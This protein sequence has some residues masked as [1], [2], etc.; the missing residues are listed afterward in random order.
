MPRVRRRTDG[1]HGH[2]V[3]QVQGRLQRGRTAKRVPDEDV[4]RAILLA[5]PGRRGNEVGDV[6]GKGG[7]AESAF[8]LAQPRKIE[9]Q[10]SDALVDEGSAHVTRSLQVLRAGEAVGE[11][12]PRDRLVGGQVENTGQ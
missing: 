2:H 3:R 5:K 1:C 10:H 8:T 11:N 6:G 9:A 12:G 4:R 7:L